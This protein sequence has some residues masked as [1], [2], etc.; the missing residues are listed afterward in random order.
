MVSKR[1][2]LLMAILLFSALAV[3]AQKLGGGLL[4]GMS[5]STM[6][7][8]GNDSTRFRPGFTGGFRIALIPTH[9]VFGVEAEILY[10]QCGYGSKRAIDS[11]G[12]K[13]SYGAKSHYLEMP[14]LLNVYMRKWK[15]TDESEAKM[16]RLRVGPEIGVCIAGSDL[17]NIKGKTKKQEITPWEKG[18]FYRFHYG[19]TAAVAYWFIE[20]RYTYGISNVMKGVKPSHNHVISILFSDIW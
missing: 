1:H 7:M 12:N 16:L 20:V 9:S 14:I 6:K 4:A 13:V 15:D 5:L 3:E 19:V 17:H 2:I 11:L 8:A 18:S 10:S